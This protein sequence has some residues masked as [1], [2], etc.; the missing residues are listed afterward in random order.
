METGSD[1]SEDVVG[2]ICMCGA[3]IGRRE[4]VY[5]SRFVDAI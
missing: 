1:D 4:Y 3:L 2:E 5:V